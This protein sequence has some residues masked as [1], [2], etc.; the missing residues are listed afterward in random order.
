MAD[1]TDDEEKRGDEPS[2]NFVAPRSKP[3]DTQKIRLLKAVKQTADSANIKAS[4][5]AQAL[6]A[7]KTQIEDAQTIIKQNSD[8]I[9]GIQARAEAEKGITALKLSFILFFYLITA[10]ICFEIVGRHLSLPQEVIQM[11]WAM[12]A[13]PWV[14]HGMGKLVQALSSRFGDKTAIATPTETK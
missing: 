4:Q 6:P 14:G 12:I 11:A 9:E 1:E 8:A 13:G 2:S 5:T 10:Y 7:L 3:D